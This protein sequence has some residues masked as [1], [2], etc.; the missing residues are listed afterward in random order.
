MPIVDVQVVTHASD[1]P[2]RSLARELADAI[3]AALAAPLGRVWARLSWL[4]TDRYAENG[5]DLAEVEM[6]VFVTLLHADPPDGLA[7]AAEAQAV[8]SAVAA[9]VGRSV[10][11]VHVEYAPA[12]RGRI[13][14][15]GK[16]LA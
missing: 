13:A 8:A 1:A 11:R 3:G 5:C 2:R 16:L 15:G 4:P 7:R 6:P 9:C 12:G 10:D 14:F